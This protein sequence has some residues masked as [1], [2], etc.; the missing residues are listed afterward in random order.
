MA[1]SQNDLRTVRTYSLL[2][3]TER[4]IVELSQKTFRSKANVIDLAVAEL[5]QRIMAGEQVDASA[6]SEPSVTR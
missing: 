4:M 1:Q 6:Q 2:E 3:T 5:Y